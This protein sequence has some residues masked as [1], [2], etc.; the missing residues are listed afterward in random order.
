M[1]TRNLSDP[2][3]G[4]PNAR[5]AIASIPLSF[6]ERGIRAIEGAGVPGLIEDILAGSRPMDKRTVHTRGENGRLTAIPMP[7]G[8]HGEVTL[9]QTISKS[10]VTFHSVSITYLEKRLQNAFC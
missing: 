1:T 5:P 6:S 9:I 7:Y 4:D 2:N 3:F 10:C 8:P